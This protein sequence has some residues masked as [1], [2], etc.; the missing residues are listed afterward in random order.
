MSKFK[1]GDLVRCVRGDAGWGLLHGHTYEVTSLH[2]NGVN[3]FVNGGKVSNG[4]AWGEDRFEPIPDAQPEPQDLSPSEQIRHDAAEALEKWDAKR[5]DI[6]PQSASPSSPGRVEAQAR[7]AAKQLDEVDPVNH[8]PHYTQHPS[9]V[10]CITVTE[11]MNFCCGN[12]V[13]YIWRAGEKGD[14]VEDLR[15]AVWYLTREIERLE[16]MKGGE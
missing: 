14:A 12:A 8:P 4:V 2:P 3:V 6:G 9:G 13:K 10:E 15:K 11:H 7:E 16:R 5:A 1:V